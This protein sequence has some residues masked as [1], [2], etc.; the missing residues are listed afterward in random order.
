MK[1]YKVIAGSLVLAGIALEGAAI[2]PAKLALLLFAAA[3]LLGDWLIN[4]V[5]PARFSWAA[6]L[7]RAWGIKMVG[8]LLLSA[9]AVSATCPV[10]AG[11]Y[12]AAGAVLL[13]RAL[14]QLLHS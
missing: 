4:D 6:P 2:H 11:L 5:L 8:T 12:A 9:S 1:A 7:N 14:R 10:A 13:G 3:V